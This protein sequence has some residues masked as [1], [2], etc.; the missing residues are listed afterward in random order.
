[1]TV[2]QLI[3]TALREIV[4]DIWPLCCPEE[5]PPDEF[6][7]YNPEIEEAVLYGD[8]EDLEWACYMQVHLYTRNDYSEQR[9]RIRKAL[10]K[11]GFMVTDIET[12]YEKD[13]KYYHL[14]FSCNIEEDMEE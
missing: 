8:N 13:S 6:I 5:R 14:C 9:I 3:E 12:M 1:M 2:N 11:A 10:R 7:V 4:P